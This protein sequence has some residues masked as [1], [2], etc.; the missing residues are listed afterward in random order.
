LSATI[1]L[2]H[3]WL[4]D[5]DNKLSY[6]LGINAVFK[7]YYGKLLLGTAYRT[8]DYDSYIT[9]KTYKNDFDASK[10]EANYVDS[11]GVNSFV[12][13]APLPLSAYPK[14]E[15][16]EL[17]TIEFQA[18][19]WIG[20]HT[21][22][23]ITFY[24]NHYTNYIKGTKVE[25][26]NGFYTDDREFGVNYDT[27]DIQ[28]VELY[29][30]SLFF[31]KLRVVL[32]YSH[33]FLATEDLGNANSDLVLTTMLEDGEHDILGLSNNILNMTLNYQFT[34]KFYS[35]LS[36]SYYSERH[37]DN[38]YHT[39]VELNNYFDVTKGSESNKNG[40]TT[41]DLNG[42]YA[43]NKVSSLSFNIKNL[44]DERR[45][46]PQLPDISRYDV[47]LPRRSVSITYSY[48]F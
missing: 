11:S 1:G 31:N 14:V 21:Q 36:L 6:R 12:E 37:L 26:N 17:T 46:N 18:G 22:V 4:T 43:F 44:L 20:D 19:R 45:Y 35:T 10:T 24:N 39:D 48:D 33:L 15:A 23:D 5:F 16:E 34:P 30:R 32:S 3:S 38:R 8:P 40:F 28:G 13:G 29:W 27:R 47:E 2:R 9:R 25:A 41:V 7:E 42:K